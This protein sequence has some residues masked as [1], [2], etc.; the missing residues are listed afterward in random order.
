[1]KTFR[2]YHKKL[3]KYVAKNP[4]RVSGYITTLTLTL[5]KIYNF[6]SLGLLIFFAMLFIGMGES[7]QRAED[8]KTIR[9]LYIKNIGTVPDEK[10]LED[11]VDV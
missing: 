4:A 9:A 2:K 5:N 1:M 3:R 6:K 7:A 10:L 8:K 11:T